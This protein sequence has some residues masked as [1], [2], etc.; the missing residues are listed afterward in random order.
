MTLPTA[1]VKKGFSDHPIP[2]MNQRS[3]LPSVSNYSIYFMF[4]LMFLILLPLRA[5]VL[6]SEEELWIAGDLWKKTQ[7]QWNVEKSRHAEVLKSIESSNMSVVEAD[8]RLQQEFGIHKTRCLELKKQRHEV[9]NI[10][11]AETNGRLKGGKF[12]SRSSSHRAANTGSPGSKQVP[13]V[14]GPQADNDTIIKMKETLVDMG[15]ETT[16]TIKE[17]ARNPG[18][19]V[20]EGDFEISIQK[21]GLKAKEG[22]G[23]EDELLKSDAENSDV[24]VS[25]SMQSKG[26]PDFGADYVKI[27]DQYKQVHDVLTASDELLLEKKS[28]VQRLSKTIDLLFEAHGDPK[29]L[30]YEVNSI[31]NAKLAYDAGALQKKI[32]DIRTGKN[33]I[34][35]PKEAKEL[36]NLS[37]AIFK[38][39]ERKAFRQAQKQVKVR[40]AE[41]KKIAKMQERLK[42]LPDNPKTKA[43]RA[44]LQKSFNN[45]KANLRKG[46]SKMQASKN[47]NAYRKVKP[48]GK[49]NASKILKVTGDFLTIADLGNAC[50]K[51][52]E[53]N[54]G[55]V[56]LSAVVRST[57]NLTPAAPLVNSAE[58]AGASA[59]DL[60]LAIK[61]TKEANENNMIAYLDQ[62]ELRFQKAGMTKQLARRYISA[63]VLGGNFEILEGKA[64]LLRSQ[65]EKIISPKLTVDHTP[66]P[67]GGNWF[68][69]ENFKDMVVGIGKSAKEGTEYIVTAP[70][71]VVSSWAEG[72]L[73]EA[74]LD[75]D[76]KTATTEMKTRL[77]RKLLN[78]GI[79]S[80]RAMQAVQGSQSLLKEVAR[81]AREK[82]KEIR[83]EEEKILAE[84][85]VFEQKL[86]ACMVEISRLRFADALIKTDPKSPLKVPV[87][88]AENGGVFPVIV[89][90]GGSL[91]DDV[92]VISRSLEQLTGVA[93]S[94]QYA[95]AFSVKSAVEL[96]P[97]RWELEVPGEAGSYPVKIKVT[98]VISSFPGDFKPIHRTIIRT[99]K[100]VIAVKPSFENIRFTKNRYEL[101]SGF[102]EELAVEITNKAPEGNYFFRWTIDGK[103]YNTTEPSTTYT[104]DFKKEDCPKTIKASV[105]LCDRD[106]GCLLGEAGAS[107]EVSYVELKVFVGRINREG[108]PCEFYTAIQ[109]TT[110]KMWAGTPG[111]NYYMVDYPEGGER[112]GKIQWWCIPHGPYRAYNDED[113]KTLRKTGTYKNGMKDGKWIDYIESG[114]LKGKI[115]RMDS[116]RN[117]KLHGTSKIYSPDDGFMTQLENHKNGMKDGENTVYYRDGGRDVEIYSED[118]LMENTVYGAGGSLKSVII[119]HHNGEQISGTKTVYEEDGEVEVTHF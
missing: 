98:V 84:E 23:L 61:A 62:W 29:E 46:I 55:K 100:G 20:T 60:Y 108:V 81:E 91:T 72:E 56:P 111:E 93:P 38:A 24:Q 95:Y 109:S 15:L 34:K 99:V 96:S 114:E 59:S 17:S 33:V 89:S 74:T 9:Q 97:S 82:M 42:A 5:G 102:S 92:G 47:A 104:P 19:L 75:Y 77:F 49:L 37:E 22:S 69:W 8:F 115:R 65:G 50:K 45:K 110:T 1:S 44:Q 70:Y 66:G 105:L 10:L 78:A 11:I 7:A 103:S 101:N 112:D 35:T 63:A 51:Y 28:M 30:T 6:Y 21:S 18:T 3:F 43:K 41:L 94:V 12:Q 58:K 76:S 13:G 117:G 118:K 40:K 90:L 113:G 4:S 73:K 85:Q 26:T 31:I 71:R 48:K 36:K 57:L 2:D 88:A 54:E 25:Q 52:E 16:L 86:N 67:D 68:L 64:D 14:A 116:Y 53:Y 83:E 27:Q 32:L 39:A 106:T 107:L 119:Y 80:K 79:S 87:D